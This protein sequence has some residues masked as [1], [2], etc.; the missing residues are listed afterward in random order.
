MAIELSTA[1]AKFK[2]AVEATA[3]VR[4]TTGYT[5]IPGLKEIPG[6]N[7]EPATLETTTLDATGYKTYI[8]GLKD[9]GGAL[10]FKANLS[11]EFKTAWEGLMT[12]YLAAKTAG[13]KTYFTVEIP[14]ITEAIFL[15]GEPSALG[16]PTLGVDSVIETDVYITP[17]GEPSWETKAS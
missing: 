13:K 9:L 16:M 15:S 6:L 14:G 10:T 5:A 7:P 3:G 12:A 8:P 1:G 2:Y 11:E 4:P 17:T